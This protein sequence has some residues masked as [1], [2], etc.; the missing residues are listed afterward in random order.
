MCHFSSVVDLLLVICC[1]IFVD[2]IG[3]Q[4]GIGPGK[5]LIHKCQKL[6]FGELL[7]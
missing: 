5:T 3:Q 2:A 1:I 4:Q 7:T 6:L